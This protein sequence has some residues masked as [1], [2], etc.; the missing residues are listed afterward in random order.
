MISEI[1]FSKSYSSFWNEYTPWLNNYVEEVN[2]DKTLFIED[3]LFVD[4]ESIYRS[5]NSIVSF[6]R[7]KE[8][9]KGNDIQ[10]GDCLQL[11]MD[12]INLF[13]RTNI[14]TYT[15]TDANI[16]AIIQIS[17]RLYKRYNKDIKVNPQFC[18]CGVIDNCNGDILKNETL[19]EIKAGK[20]KISATDIKQMITY[21]ALNN[22]THAFNIQEF[23]LYNPRTGFL[24]NSN[25]QVLI[26]DISSISAY[27]LCDEI[28]KYV[29]DMTEKI[30][31]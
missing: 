5:I 10:T 31:Y 26:S 28:G 19:V 15:L 9:L 29:S 3:P 12:T 7:Y 2:T 16:Q 21:Y 24:W 25:I 23:E 18:G 1:N 20:R 22:H 6:T 13:P 27:E 30:I 4:D 17:D 11:A 8:L 14:E